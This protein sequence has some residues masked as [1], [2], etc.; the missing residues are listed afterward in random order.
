MKKEIEFLFSKFK[1]TTLI[2]KNILN[3]SI[4]KESNGN[5]NTSNILYDYIDDKGVY[6]LSEKIYNELNNLQVLNITNNRN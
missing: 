5:V 6:E 1:E 3:T 4:I 2:H